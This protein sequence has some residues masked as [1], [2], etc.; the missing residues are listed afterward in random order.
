MTTT[1]R[2]LV[3]AGLKNVRESGGEIKASCPVPGHGQ[4]NGDRNPSLSIWEKEDG[5]VDLKCYAGCEKNTVLAAIG[6]TWQ[7]LYPPREEKARR[8]PIS[9]SALARAKKLPVEVLRSFGLA[10]LPGGKVGIPY[11]DAARAVVETKTRTALAAKEGSFWPKGK[12]LL[13]YGLDHLGMARQQ[14]FLVLV[15]GESDCW[16]LWHHA[17][18]GLG[19][20]GVD[21]CKVLEAGHLTGIS[22]IYFIQEP[23]AGEQAFA[24]KIPARLKA[25]GFQGRVIPVRLEAKDPNALHQR[26]PE[27]F[28]EAFRAALSL[29]ETLPPVEVLTSSVA[30]P[31]TTPTDVEDAETQLAALVERL[32]TM[33]QASRDAG[34]VVAA[35][36][37]FNAVDTPTQASYKQKLKG[38]LG[39]ALNLNDLAKQQKTLRKQTRPPKTERGPRREDL[40]QIIVGDIH[41]RDLTAQTVAALLAANTPEPK[42]FVRGG[43]LVQVGE[44]EKHNPKVS[45]VSRAALRNHMGHA[46]NYVRE[47]VTE[48]TT[49]YTPEF[50]PRDAVDAVMAL[51]VWPFPPLAGIVESPV[52]RPDGTILDTPGYD[53]ATALFYAPTAGFHMPEVLAE[54]TREDALQALSVLR[55]PFEQFPYKNAASWA[56][57]LAMF[58]SPIVRPA[59]E[60]P[61]PLGLVDGT[62]A[63]TGKGLLVETAGL[64]ATGRN[65]AMMSVPT[66]NDEELRKKL[67]SVLLGS[68]MLVVLDNIE[69]PLGSPDLALMLTSRIYS[70]RKLGVHEELKLPQ[71]AVWVATGNNIKLRGDIPRRAYWIRLDA[72][73]ARPWEREEFNIP[74]LRE[75]VTENRG[76]LLAA[77]LTIAR[78]WWVAGKPQPKAKVPLLGSFEE[79]CHT[80]AGILAYVGVDG[81][82]GNQ[83]ELYEQVDEENPEWD[84]FFT[85]WHR[86]FG[87]TPVTTAEVVLKLAAVEEFRQAIPAPLAHSYGKEGESF[88]RRLGKALG[89]HA[90]TVWESG[91]RLERAT[92]GGA[93]AHKR[94]RVAKPSESAPVSLF[95]LFEKPLQPC[96]ED[97][98]HSGNDEGPEVVPRA[99][100]NRAV[101]TGETGKRGNSENGCMSHCWACGEEL[102]PFV[103]HVCAA[104]IT[105]A[106]SEGA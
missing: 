54:P 40:P 50:P 34:E 28:P 12:P 17:F 74:N 49:Y 39:S 11:H 79:W 63:G 61:V 70:D 32:A 37:L 66:N 2:D 92:A 9:V 81:F 72:G 10:D 102:K 78:A 45:V 75:W 52:L 31:E 97:T 101:E 51:G 53:A 19:I 46:A 4:G 21:A 33:D 103:A 57:A 36:N 42:L 56:N 48:E 87:T 7:N 88:D 69:R 55:K 76:E 95:S 64:I 3:T 89:K 60:G 25:L 23:D 8:E 105:L 38:L 5:S 47:V 77:I 85:I 29:A 62:K 30:A 65:P 99:Y 13:A 14:G 24:R 41:L 90:D 67:T 94:W 80:L 58:L 1:P 96:G 68:P 100:S 22:T 6:L 91:L 93:K 15:E 82:L 83:G 73:V 98:T 26:D 59:I 104:D 43:V 35:A 44:D 86:V 18:P 16:T 27:G 106:Y 20:P 71:R 84:T